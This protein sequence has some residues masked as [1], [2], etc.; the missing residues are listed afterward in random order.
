MLTDDTKFTLDTNA[1]IY[2]VQDDPRAILLLEDILSKPAY[3]L[4]VSTISEIELFSFSAL[5]EEEAERIDKLL[6][7][8]SLISLDSYI[9][10]GAARI[11]ATYHLENP[12]SVVAA[13]ALFTG[14]TLLTRNVDDFKKNPAS[15]FAGD[16]TLSRKRQW[17]T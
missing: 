9:A 10:R 7:G 14:S 4:Y 3:P 17:A 6:L 5:P 16:L 15:F 8:V 2:Y 12:D 1:I 13:T 11:R